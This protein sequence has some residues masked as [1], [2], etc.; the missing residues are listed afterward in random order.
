[1]KLNTP[2][3]QKEAPVGPAA[4]ILSTTDTKGAITYINQDFVDISGFTPEEVLGKNHNV[5]RHPDMPPQA[6]TQ[7]WDAVHGGH[8]W[9]GIVKNRCK[10]GDHYWVDAYVTPILQNGQVAEYQSVRRQASPEAI[11]RAEKLYACLLTDHSAMRTKTPRMLRK[12][13]SASSKLVLC[14]A[15]PAA[16]AVAAHLSLQLNPLASVGVWLGAVGAGLLG[17][18]VTLSPLLKAVKA[19]RLLTDDPVARHVYTGRQDEAGQLQLALKMFQ[20]ENSG[21]IGRIANSAERIKYCSQSL[22]DSVGRCQTEITHQF[23]ET[24]QVA[25]AI[26][27]MSASITEVSNSA[28]GSSSRVQ[29]GQHTVHAGHAV[30]RENVAAIEALAGE[31]QDVATVVSSVKSSSEAVTG[32][33][34]TIS[35]IAEQTNLLALNAAIEAAR[36]GEAGRGF[37][38]VADEVRQLATRTRD[39]TEQ[40]HTLIGDLQSRSEQAVKAMQQGKERAQICVAQG[41]EAATALSA[42]VNL[43]DEISQ[44]NLQ[45]ASAVDQQSQAADEINRNI[46][47]IRDASEGSLDS[48][49]HSASAGHSL[50]GMASAF[51]QLADQFW[52]KKSEKS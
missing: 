9:M 39:A 8:S 33:L 40:V 1:M 29:E 2:V 19:T 3:T 6:F 28:Q 52:A 4:N 21:L 46:L 49:E 36:A 10:N 47:L 14:A 26:N 25:A 7:L 38:V 50:H 12:S 27:E 42:I 30:V 44:M 18:L 20:A 17:S 15:M 45:I 43:F 13:L 35:G 37:A 41:E 34:D 51:S 5:V 48:M 22:S 24:D 16:A 23:G 11:A 31:I 32:I